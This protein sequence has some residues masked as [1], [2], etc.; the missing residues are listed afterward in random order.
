MLKSKII[1]FLS[2]IISVCL[3]SI[4][5]KAAEKIYL[6]YGPL[7]F[8]LRVESLEEFAETGA[9]DEELAFYLS[10][11]TPKKREA[12]REILNKKVE[13]NPVLLSRFFNSK[14][15]ESMLMRLGT[16]ITIQGGING[17][18][19]L[20]GAMVQAS[21]DSEG[22][23]LLNV[24]KQFPTNIQLKGEVIERTAKEAETLILATETLVKD[25]RI[26]TKEEAQNAPPVDYVNLIDPRQS[27]QYQVKKEVWHLTD[28]TRDRSFYINVYIPQ[29]VSS[30][31]I[32]II[33]FSHGL[34]SRPE[35]F[36]DHMNHLASY[37]YLLA[38]PQHV[39]SDVIYLKEMFEGYHKNIFDVNEFINRPLDIS[40]VIDELERR[41]QSQ[42]AGKLD[43]DNVGVG[44]HSFG[45][46]TALA[47]AGATIDFDYLQQSCDRFYGDISTSL[48]LTC[49]AL[50]LPRENYQFK[51]DRVQG[52][53]VANPVNRYIFGQ[54][55]I[56][57]IDI[58]VILFS[59]SKDPATP[60]AL[61]QALPFEWLTV[62]DKYW[63]MI[64]GQAH[65]NFTKLDGGIAKTI[66]TTNHLTFPSQSLIDKYIKG[67]SLAFFQVYIGH[68]ED[69]RVYLQSSYAEYLSQ[70][71][72][73]E[74][75]LIS[76]ASSAKLKAAIEEFRREHD[77][78]S[79]E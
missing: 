4:P 76:E 68:N 61:E 58:P 73:F 57:Q 43:V 45:G 75:S 13:V 33:V 37:G 48:I 51:D 42:F 25:L 27:G 38:A 18:Y 28:S 65:V 53:L 5:V 67:I 47:V 21:F 77:R 63:A 2:G 62:T 24:L 66:E 6:S 14:M 69:Y 40:F 15:G 64:E 20:R 19:A 79:I 60:P 29:G 72:R 30:K 49:R 59:G 1:L 11:V 54:T 52:V 8:P 31:E 9:I 74:V 71:E 44:G 16:A 22:L 41:N 17:G 23:T 70:N 56:S 12:F 36:E 10:R 50:E 26:W 34:S 7:M 39:G 35:D 32:P 46:Y 3:S 78:E 55:G